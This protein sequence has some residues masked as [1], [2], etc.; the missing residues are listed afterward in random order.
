[1]QMVKV[2]TL[3]FACLVLTAMPAMAAG[4]EDAGAYGYNAGLPMAIISWVCFLTLLLVGGKVAWKPILA[5]LDARETRIRESLENAE[6]IESQ[7]AD[8]EAS[9][10]KLISDAE[11][12]AKTIITEA[13]E[14]AQ[15]LAKEINETAK[16]E[17][18]SLRE[19]ALKDIE[20]ARAKAVSSLRDESAELA[21]TLAG[22]LIGENL[23]SEKSRVLTDKIIDTL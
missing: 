22:K 7:L 14:T 1:M 18:Q 17:A 2:K 21:V 8:A 6:K 23:D 4:G 11:T 20:N 10:K 12:S 3:A 9:R 13:K 19:N 16:A 15:K 5:N